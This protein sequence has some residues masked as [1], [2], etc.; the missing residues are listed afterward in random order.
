L[1]GSPCLHEC[2]SL[3]SYCFYVQEFLVYI[4]LNQLHF[5]K[6]HCQ[7]FIFVNRRESRPFVESRSISILASTSFVNILHIVQYFFMSVLCV[8]PCSCSQTITSEKKL[9]S[10]HIRSYG[11]HSLFSSFAFTKRPPRRF[12]ISISTL[13]SSFLHLL[14]TDTRIEVRRTHHAQQ[15]L[16]LYLGCSFYFVSK[17]DLVIWNDT[18]VSA[19]HQR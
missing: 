15:M 8:H 3:W 5:Q 10:K 16:Q 17:N 4:I 11:C 12:N 7:Y 6:Y 14:L 1:Q 2:K 13:T 18:L 19:V 9:V